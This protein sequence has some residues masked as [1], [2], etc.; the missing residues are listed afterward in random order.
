MGAMAGQECVSF[1]LSVCLETLLLS[2]CCQK[3]CS[4]CLIDV[5]TASKGKGE[6]QGSGRRQSIFSSD[7][8]GTKVQ[9]C[10]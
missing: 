4:I 5:S 6:G 2:S 1:C 9:M 7:F 3:V 10:L 8:S